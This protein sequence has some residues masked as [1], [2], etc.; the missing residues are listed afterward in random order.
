MSQSTQWNLLNEVY[1]LSKSDVSS[2]SMTRDFQT[3][4]FAAFKQF[5]I[6][7]H[8]ANFRQL[9]V[10]PNCSSLLTLG[11]SVILLTLG[12]TLGREKQSKPSPFDK[13]IKN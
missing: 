1:L 8:F 9:K 2:F 7:S 5:K 3:G 12:K 4:N 11:R 10:D 13:K 6:D